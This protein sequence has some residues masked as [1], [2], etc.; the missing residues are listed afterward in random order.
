MIQRIWETF[1]AWVKGLPWKYMFAAGLVLSLFLAFFI[2]G[3]LVWTDVV[4]IY[5]YAAIV[6]V[7]IWKIAKNNS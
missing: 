4:V 1:V 6:V 5:L 3:T 7:V 2:R